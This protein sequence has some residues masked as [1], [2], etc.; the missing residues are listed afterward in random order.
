MRG[1]AEARTADPGLLQDV[2]ALTHPLRVRDY[3]AASYSH[4]DLEDLP[5]PGPS[6][7]QEYR[8]VTARLTGEPIRVHS[9]FAKILVSR[10]ALTNDDRGFVQAAVGAFLAQAHRNELR[11]VSSLLES[12]TMTDGE[13]I[14]H[15]DFA[16]VGSG[17]VNDAGLMGAVLALRTQTTEGGVPSNA[18]PAV[19]LVH[20]TDEVPALQLVQTLPEDRRPRVVTSAF[21]A[22]THWYLLADPGVYPIVGRVLLDGAG[23]SAVSFGPFEQASVL[24]DGEQ[25]DYN[26]LALPATHSCWLLRAEPHRRDPHGEVIARA[27]PSFG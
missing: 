6:E 27:V 23:E 17:I 11:T 9:L 10:E 15:A 13:P 12:G 2:L 25:V 8:V 16:N 20:P 22:D 1:L 21:L 19:L 4:V 14:F 26:G 24:R 7:M 5:A 18:R 3:R